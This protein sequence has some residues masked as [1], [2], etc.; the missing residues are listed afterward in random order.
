MCAKTTKSRY[1]GG[2]EEF[3]QLVIELQPA[4]RE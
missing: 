3:E 4:E 1:G 2:A